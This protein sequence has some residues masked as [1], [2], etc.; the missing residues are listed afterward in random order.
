MTTVAVLGG[1]AG[2]SATAVDLSG[3]GH[4]V[5]LWNRNPATVAPFREQGIVYTGVLGEGV[6]HPQEITT[7]LPDALDGADVAVV[8]LPAIAHGSLA[9]DLARVGVDV[10]VVLHPGHTGGALHVRSVLVSHGAE[11]PPIAE[12][13][14]LSYVAR[15]YTPETVTITGYAGRIYAACLPRGAAALDSALDLFPSAKPV[16]DV[17]VTGLA[18]V[19]MVLHPPGAI[20]AAAWVEA[21]GGDFTFYVDAMTSGV[22]RVMQR[23]D[24][25]RLAVAGAF[26]HRMPDLLHEM[27]AIGTVDEQAADAGDLGAAIRGGEANRHIRAPGSLDHRY[28][29]ED[30]GYGLLPFIELARV[31]GV[32]VPVARS[33]LEIAAA[34]VD[35]DGAV[36]GLDAE[37]LGIAGCDRDGVLALVRSGHAVAR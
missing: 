23:L 10:P 15:R 32:E 31:V 29:A 13:S 8:C 27:A 11:V 24:A 4:D 14:T 25:E 20:L 16:A 17:L 5:R 26:G 6:V 36:H 9:H 18:N 37:G 28:Y 2:G 1:G 12:M 34:A 7:D 3:R 30:F 19:N 33:L 35:R 22:A 21:T